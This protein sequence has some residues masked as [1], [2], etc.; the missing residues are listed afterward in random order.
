MMHP[1][2]RRFRDPDTERRYREAYIDSDR[3]QAILTATIILVPML[4]F[5]FTDAAFFAGKG[6]PL[7]L[8]LARAGIVAVSFALI[9]RLRWDIG[10][11]AFDRMM[12]AWW[13]LLAA[14]ILYVNSTRPPGYLLHNAIDG[15]LAMVTFV[16]PLIAFPLQLLP[17]L[18]LATGNVIEAVSVR[19]VVGVAPVI[20][21]P[22]TYLMVMCIGSAAAWR[23]HGM[24]REQWLALQEQYALQARLE[25]LANTDA[26]TGVLNRRQF[27]AL[28]EAELVRALRHRRPMGLLVLDLDHFKRINDTWG[29][30]TGDQALVA[31]AGAIAHELRAVDAFARMGGEEFAVLLPETPPVEVHR[32]AE[33]LRATVAALHWHPTEAGARLT[34]SI[35]TASLEAGDT[36]V[37]DVLRRADKALYEAKHAGRNR[38]IAR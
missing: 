8:V 16:L 18:V 33:R 9:A 20:V 23:L 31:V 4:G 1:I 28:G 21:L 10:P 37:A 19:D 2:T 6:I 25:E 29:H 15:A 7:Q 5:A 22:I 13:L 3:R 12:G 11:E 26:L 24:R 35:G 27:M 36:T 34:L 17:P 14:F 30:E 32:V 38:V